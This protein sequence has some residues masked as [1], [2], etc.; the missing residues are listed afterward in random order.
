MTYIRRKYSNKKVN[1]AKEK[2]SFELSLKEF[3]LL[4]VDAGITVVDL[5][6]KGYHLSRYNDSGSYSYTNCRFVPYY[7]NFSE[8]KISEKAR[9]SS[10]KNILRHNVSLSKEEYVQRGLKAAA[11]RKIRGTCTGGHNR[12]SSDIINERLTSIKNSDIDLTRY[13]WV[14]KVSKLLGISHT[15][16]RRFMN[17]YYKEAYYRRK[18]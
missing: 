14:N 12:L 8:K 6:V 15:Q 11:T 5:G 18:K 17:L 2:I 3:I 7:V 10:R 9:R 4:M 13:G 16:V 1:A